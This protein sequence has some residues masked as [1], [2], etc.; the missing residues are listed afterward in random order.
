MTDHYDALETR[1]A[2][3]RDAANFGRLPQILAAAAKAPAYAERFNGIDLVSVTSR[4]ALAKLPVLRKSDLPGLHKADP[5]FGG[6]VA[7]APGSFGRLFTSPGPI[8]DPEGPLITQQVQDI[9]G[10]EDTVL[11]GSDGV[12]DQGFLDTAGDIA[13]E[14]GMYFSGPDLN[15]GD[16]YENDFLPK[17]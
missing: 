11:F 6:F 2:A 8:F 7:H 10:L 17:Y 3:E 16:R 4:A 5:P 9:A 12:K 1:S 15:F 13:E 14:V